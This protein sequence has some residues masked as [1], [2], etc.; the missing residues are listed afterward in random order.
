[1]AFEKF[2]NLNLRSGCRPW[3]D[4]LTI[5]L[6]GWGRFRAAPWHG[7]GAFNGGKDDGED[8]K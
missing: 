7:L 2:K 3:A 1:L 5:K 4:T 8:A 6:A